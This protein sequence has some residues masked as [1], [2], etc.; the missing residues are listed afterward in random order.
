MLRDTGLFR[1][2]LNRALSQP[3][4]GSFEQLEHLVEELMCQDHV[5]RID[6]WSAAE[7]GWQHLGTMENIRPTPN[8]DHGRVACCA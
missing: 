2:E 5:E 1:V 4:N 6:V 8:D 7:R 3:F